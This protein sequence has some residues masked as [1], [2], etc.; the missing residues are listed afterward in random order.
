MPNPSRT[1]RSSVRAGAFALAVLTLVGAAANAQAQTPVARYEQPLQGR[2][3]DSRGLPLLGAFVAVIALG[4]DQPE[5]IV[6]TDERGQ[7][8][9]AD[10]REGVYSLLVGSLGFVGAVVQGVSVPSAA[11]LTLQLE[12]ANERELSALDGPL[13]LSWALRSR[14]RDVLRQRD[15]TLVSD[16]GGEVAGPQGR[17]GSVPGRSSV[18]GAVAGEFRLWSFTRTGDR[19]TVGVTSLSLSNGDTWS[20]TAHLGNTG[21]VWAA[22]EMQ[23]G[24][25]AGHTLHVGFGYVGGRFDAP[26]S[27]DARVAAGERIEPERDGRVGRVAAYDEWRVLQPLR[28]RYGVEYQHENY[29]ADTNLLSPSLEVAYEP[30]ADTQIVTGVSYT[31]QGLDLARESTGFEIMSLLGYSNLRIAD[32][33]QMLPQRSWRYQLAVQRQ[34]GDARVRVKAYYDDVTDELLG[35]YVSGDGG[36]GDYLLFNLGSSVTRGFEFGVA[37]HFLDAFSGELVY[38]FRDRESPVDVPSADALGDV[39]VAG[40][41]FDRTHEV[42]A[43]VAAELAPSHT[44]L[45]A[46]YNWRQGVPVVRDGQIFSE[47]GRI[48]L[49]VRQLLPFRALD[50]EWSAMVQIRNLLGPEYDGLYDVSLAELL[51]LTRGIAGGL[52]VRF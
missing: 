9:V 26:V 40:L 41:R 48:D 47:Y 50:T 36:V 23:R 39:D 35:V 8:R 11:P 49:R 18:A 25:G 20:V 1:S 22:G 13:D 29:L 45:T 16:T 19:E 31:E 5:A 3:Y 42:K 37:A 32:T 33:Q 4:A 51:G 21:A 30:D 6:V 17:W 24:L 28:I 44:R 27:P 10:L 46:V 12:R 38:A 52:A 14:E 34:I 43:S 2:V 15:A 7:F